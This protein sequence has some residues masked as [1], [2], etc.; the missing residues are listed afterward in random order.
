[1]SRIYTFAFVGVA[2]FTA[3][4][5]AHGDQTAA[6]QVNRFGDLAQVSVTAAVVN[7]T[8]GPARC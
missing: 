7:V 8:G 5:D 1:V 6:D 4:T 2:G 3:L